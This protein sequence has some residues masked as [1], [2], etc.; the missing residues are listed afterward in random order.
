MLSEYV[1]DFGSIVLDGENR[2]L[3][4][5]NAVTLRQYLTDLVLRVCRRSSSGLSLSS[6]SRTSRC[7]S[8]NWDRRRSTRSSSS[9]GARISRWWPPRCLRLQQQPRFE[10]SPLTY[11]LYHDYNPTIIEQYWGQLRDA[12]RA[13]ADYPIPE[14]ATL[15]AGMVSRGERGDAESPD[16]DPR[17][18]SRR[19]RVSEDVVGLA[20]EW[21]MIASTWLAPPRQPRRGGAVPR[22]RGD[23]PDRIRRWL[24]SLGDDSG[25]R[26]CASDEAQERQGR[27]PSSPPGSLTF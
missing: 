6:S 8:Q 1:C 2:F 4:V 26:L 16:E 17:R 25:R 19:H 22:D 23:E 13:A 15:R 18:R 10:E 11:N 9:A 7:S 5:V 14:S 21:R 24:E 20:Q 3:A 12:V 27:A